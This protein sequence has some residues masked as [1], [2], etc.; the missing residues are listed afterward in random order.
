MLGPK[1]V[2]FLLYIGS[3]YFL[4]VLIPGSCCL[5]VLFLFYSCSTLVLLLFFSCS[6]LVLLLFYSCSTLVLLLFGSSVLFNTDDPN[7]TRTKQYPDKSKSPLKRQKG[8]NGTADPEC[9]GGFC[10]MCLMMAGCKT[11]S[12]LSD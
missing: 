2:R 9:P 1:H 5:L 8:A 4:N 12:L 6:T 7:K 3:S 11:I 10:N